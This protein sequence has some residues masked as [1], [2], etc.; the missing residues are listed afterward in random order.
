MTAIFSLSSLIDLSFEKNYKQKVISILGK[1]VVDKIQNL[2]ANVM[3]DGSSG[4]KFVYRVTSF[5]KLILS[6]KVLI[7]KKKNVEEKEKEEALNYLE[8]IAHDFCYDLSEEMMD[9]NIADLQRKFL[10]IK[11][12]KSS[13]GSFKQIEDSFKE[14]DSIYECLGRLDSVYT[15]ALAD[16]RETLS[17]YKKKHKMELKAVWA[18]AASVGIISNF[19][20]VCYFQKFLKDKLKKITE[21]I[22]CTKDE[23]ILKILKVELEELQKMNAKYQG[24]NKETLF[25]N[26]KDVRELLE[27][28]ID[29]LI[30]KDRYRERGK[31]LLTIE[32]ENYEENKELLFEIQTHIKAIKAVENR[33]I[34]CLLESKKKMILGSISYL[35]EEKLT[36]I[37][38]EIQ[39][40]IINEERLLEE[41]IRNGYLNSMEESLED[42]EKEMG[43]LKNKYSG[44]IFPRKGAFRVGAAKEQVKVLRERVIRILMLNINKVTSGMDK[45]RTMR[46]KER[47]E[48][49][50]YATV[51]LNNIK[52]TV[53]SMDQID[54]ESNPKLLEVED[55][56]QRL[57]R[58]IFFSL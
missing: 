36:N 9:S 28:K 27:N 19:T 6:C 21:D 15:N 45:I 49:F 18:L 22:K 40:E 39:N 55:Q 30:N 37:E 17:E 16:F 44:F 12:G 58:L 10:A 24:N 3:N 51:T 50:S 42:L 29:Y 25:K 23:N 8:N 26:I 56:I 57:E 54:L 38:V 41:G 34:V 1:G 33:E 48:F 13:I 35:F 7:C 2:Y 46:S 4:A 20:G 14:V 53:S 5:E 32:G 52:K 47:G 11:N 31:A 43:D